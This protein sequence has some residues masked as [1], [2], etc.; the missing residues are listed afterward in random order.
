LIDPPV[1]FS[2][3][4]KER[5]ILTVLLILFLLGLLG[6]MVLEDSA[7]VDPGSVGEGFSRPVLPLSAQSRA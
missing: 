2:L 7:A 1:P 3:T 5:K 6:M 4:R